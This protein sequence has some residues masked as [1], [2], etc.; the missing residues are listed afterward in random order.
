MQVGRDIS[1]VMI[2]LILLVLITLHTPVID[3]WILVIARDTED[4]GYSW[5]SRQILGFIVIINKYYYNKYKLATTSFRSTKKRLNKCLEYTSNK[6]FSKI[7]LFLA[8]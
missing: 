5:L 7:K 8:L 3:Q 2:P 6:A 4:R 1:L